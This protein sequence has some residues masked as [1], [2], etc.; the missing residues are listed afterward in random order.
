MQENKGGIVGYSLGALVDSVDVRDYKIA[1]FLVPASPPKKIDM[2][3]RMLGIRNQGNEG[4]C[5]AFASCAV[6]ESEESNPVYL[7]P[8]FIYDMVEQPGGGAYPRDA[9]KVLVDIGVCPETCQPYSENIRNI[10]CVNAFNLARSNK[11]KGYARLTTLEEMKQCLFQNGPFMISVGVTRKWFGGGSVIMDG[12]DI[13]GYHAVVFVGYNDETKL[14]KFRNSWGEN[15]G[16]KGYGYIRY[17]HLMKVLSDAWSS[18]DIPEEE[19][20]GYKKESFLQ[21]LKRFFKS[22]R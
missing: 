1:R 20:F 6:K 8:R 12:G 21:K 5:V 13:V 18:V 7:S 2:S 14:V 22:L 4:T 3:N 9:M 19:E 10:P 15:W 17:E 11:I 16:E